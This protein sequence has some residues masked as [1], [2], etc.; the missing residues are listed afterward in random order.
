MFTDVATSDSLVGYFAFAK[1]INHEV[2]IELHNLLLFISSTTA[3]IDWPV[4][5][6]I[7]ASMKIFLQQGK[8]FVYHNSTS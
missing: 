7:I 5:A 6:A 4:L 2:I 1:L 8:L 3:S